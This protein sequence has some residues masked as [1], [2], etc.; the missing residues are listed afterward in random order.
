MPS[1][2]RPQFTISQMLAAITC[3]AGG[4]ALVTYI[5]PTDRGPTDE[6]LGWAAAAAIGFGIGIILNRP[7]W[8]ALIGLAIA[9]A[10]QIAI[11]QPALRE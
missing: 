11:D 9:V 2:L 5:Q 1:P 10:I 6:M 8:G 3:V 7:I 4:L